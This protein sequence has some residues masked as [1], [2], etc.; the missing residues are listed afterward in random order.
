[1][2]PWSPGSWRREV[3]SKEGLVTTTT[4]GPSAGKTERTAEKAAGGGSAGHSVAQPQF[5]A[6]SASG[7]ALGGQMSPG[8]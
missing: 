1:L 3:N 8:A 2:A 4:A 5:E 7:T 6:T